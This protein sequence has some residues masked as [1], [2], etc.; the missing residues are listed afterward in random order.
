MPENQNATGEHWTRESVSILKQ[1]GW[2]Q[3]GSCN[4]DIECVHHTKERRG[5]P[6]GVDSFFE[7]YDP[8]SRSNQAILVE[9]KN[10]QFSSITTANIKKWIKQV[11]DCMECMQVSSTIQS[12]TN[13]PI[14]NALLM[15]WA[16]DEYD[17][18]IFMNNLRKVGVASK[19]YPCNLFVASNQEILKWC[20]LINMINAI[21]LQSKNFKFI[22]PNVPT[23]GTDLVLADHLTLTHLYSKYIFAESE[24][25]VPDIRGGTY[26]I[27]KLIVFCY[28]PA[29]VASLDFLYSL[30]K[31]LNFQSYPISEI[32]L[33]DKET[34]VRQ[35][36]AEF[37]NRINSEI[38]GDIAHPSTIEIKYLDIFDGLKNVPDQIIHFMEA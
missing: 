32:Y 2:T 36:A 20:S 7:Y 16:N 10:W 3:K 6:H 26:L 1:L 14:Q 4:F 21:K 33:F 23:L 31:R 37:T 12:M 38:K 15:I 13:A 19:K 22:Y 29:S 18:Q 25:Q 34:S 8:Y 30:I 17:H 24:M 27:K 5:Q 28:E 9:S 35:T 11:T